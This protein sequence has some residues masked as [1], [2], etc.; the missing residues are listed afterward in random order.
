MKRLAVIDLL[1]NWP[2]DGGARID[3]KEIASRLRRDMTV[4]MFVPDFQ[5]RCRRGD[6]R[7]ELDFEVRT[8]PFDHYSF[9]F[10]QVAKTFLREMQRYRPD[11]VLLADGWYLKPYLAIALADYAPILRFYAYESLCLRSH[12]ILFVNNQYCP[13]DFLAGSKAEVRQC[14]NCGQELFHRQHNH[15]YGQEFY[16]ALAHKPA[17]RTTVI[18]ALQ[19][20]RTIIC[21]NELIGERVRRY[22]PDVRI[23]PS[24]VDCDLF[25]PDHCARTSDPQG[26]TGSK[27]QIIFMPGRAEDPVKGFALLQQAAQILRTKRQDFEIRFTALSPVEPEE[28]YIKNVGWLS[29]DS[30]P[31]LY[32]ASHFCV[33]PSIWAEPFGIITLE[34]MACEKPVIIFNRGNLAGLVEHEKSG[35]VVS[36]GDVIALSAAMDRLLTDGRS[37]ELMGRT[38]RQKVVLGYTWDH[39]VK[40]YYQPL[41]N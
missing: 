14:I 15:H 32:N 2:P 33:I 36:D 17:Y 20:A 23:V 19:A 6:I 39:L 30:L 4:T 31:E 29:H 28:S 12:G 37:V 7:E 38:A 1:F 34:A 11:H 25:K 18:R 10:Y 27:P 3:I 16:S 21:Y 41:F 5:T 13:V 40:T 24:G 9:N 8:I 22:N 26:G 35:L